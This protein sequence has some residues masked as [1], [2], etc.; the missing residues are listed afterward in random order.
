MLSLAQ[1]SPSV[2]IPIRALSIAGTGG[3]AIFVAGTL[4]GFPQPISPTV[5]ALYPCLFLAPGAL[6]L[7]RAVLMPAERLA[8]ILF[9]T[10]AICWFGGETYYY[11][12]LED[13]AN[14]PYPSISDAFWLGA[15]VCVIIGLLALMRVRLPD[16]RRIMWI[17]AAVGGLA[18]AAIGAALLV[19][20]VIEGTGGRLAAVSTNLA[21][22][23]LD[24][25]TVSVVIA[26][27]V[28]SGGRPGRGWIVLG[29][30]FAAQ[31][32]ADMIY[33]YQSATN[34]YRFGPPSTPS[35]RP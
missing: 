34:V 26:G 15:Y 12:V 14:P 8:W 5:H 27:F 1:F 32:A 4:V 20:P 31:C 35:G 28:M 13:Q 30:V 23:L 17:D 2:R 10:S 9:G 7:L 22:P 21:Y 25:L 3:L 11:R 16:F 19:A 6:C 24:V 29:A 18:I 33:L